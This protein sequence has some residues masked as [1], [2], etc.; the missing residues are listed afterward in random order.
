MAYNRKDNPKSG[1]THN[2]ASRKPH[3]KK[4]VMPADISQP[5]ETIT[6]AYNFVS[7]PVAVLPSPM[8]GDENWN[9]MDDR[10]RH[11][12][13]ATYIAEQGSCTGRIVLRLKTLT[14]LFIGTGAKEDEFF[15]P[16][17][18]KPV[19]PGS[20]LRGM[21][22]NIFKIITAGAMRC[23]EDFVDKKLYF[24]QMIGSKNHPEDIALYNEYMVERMT[25]EVPD[26]DNPSKNISESK[27]QPG[28][29]F[30][31]KHDSTYYIAPC[32]YDPKK[33]FYHQNY[34]NVPYWTS[35]I[36]WDAVHKGAFV[37][38]KISN[39]KDPKT[40]KFRKKIKT[41]YLTKPRWDEAVS[42]PTDILNGYRDDAKR[43]GVELIEPSGQYIL[44]G[45]KAANFID[46]P[47]ITFLA[48]CFFVM[49]D[50]TVT[51]F[52]H[53]RFFRIPY[54]RSIG[55]R[56]P[57]N[58]KNEDIIDFSDAVFGRKELW[59]GRVS[60]SNAQIEGTPVF[61]QSKG[62]VKPLLS[63]NPT[64][65]QFYL[66]QTTWPPKTWDEPRAITIRGYKQ[67]WHQYISEN[68]WKADG[69]NPNEKLRHIIHPLTENNEFI[70]S[71]RFRELSP[72]ELGALLKVFQLAEQGE[73]IAYKLGLGKSLG[74]GSVN[75]T[76]TDI[77]L[78]QT[79]RYTTLFSHGQWS[80]AVKHVDAKPY[81]QQFDDYVAQ[82]FKDNMESYHEVIQEL[83]L[84][85]DWDN[86]K[87][88]QWNERV[89]M[90][91]YVPK[92]RYNKQIFDRNG[93]PRTELDKRYAKRIILPTAEAV[94]KKV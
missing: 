61:T 78:D 33:R 47:D 10:T 82:Q 46:E 26:P 59:A 5:E 86:T 76:I 90:I 23:N 75:I 35:C 69:I 85:L 15:S 40:N 74:M 50:K 25:S 45:D 38:T 58:I 51:A 63:A 2:K 29:I 91:G 64:S 31:K 36:V 24:R 41:Y 32:T 71:I 14:P 11:D 37:V 22:K 3:Y 27:T 20:T 68:G 93:N 77:Q 17:N 28:F 13:F 48:P 60:F 87:Q 70:F 1:G 39:S 80:E 42:I 92:I 54:L 81:V 56:V 83:R 19:I 88:N 73:H 8:Q 6:A 55:D 7:L 30:R 65:F 43:T 79:E 62:E 12:K 89:K 53:G 52:G 4:I 49:K 84:L 16:V 34:D 57:K 9:L 18:D 21:T 66:K 94:V 44:F 72:I 67:Y